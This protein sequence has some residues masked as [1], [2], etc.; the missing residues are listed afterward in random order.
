VTLAGA[1]AV[2]SANGGTATGAPAEGEC[3]IGGGGGVVVVV[4]QSAQPAGLTL[5]VTGG[6]SVAGAG[7]TSAMG[8]PGHS[9]WLN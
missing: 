7:A 9:Y 2:I 4:T 5:S 8:A 3:L 1:T 6:A